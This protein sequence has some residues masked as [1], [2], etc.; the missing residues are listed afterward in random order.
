MVA[1]P[2]LGVL[3]AAAATVEVLFLVLGRS[4]AMKVIPR[5]KVL[6][7]STLGLLFISGSLAGSFIS[8]LRY[9]DPRSFF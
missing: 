4:A 5:S 6:A 2:Q 3:L 9:R 1:E 8:R 7:F